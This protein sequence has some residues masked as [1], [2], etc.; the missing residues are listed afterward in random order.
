MKISLSKQV[1]SSRLPGH[2]PK[3]IH[4]ETVPDQ[5]ADIMIRKE[6]RIVYEIIYLPIDY[7]KQNP[8]YL[9]YKIEEVQK[10]MRKM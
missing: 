6:K 2:L 3:F 10:E 7:A 8:G 9:P 1:S 5:V 4:C